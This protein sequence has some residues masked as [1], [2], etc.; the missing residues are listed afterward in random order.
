MTKI[1]RWRIS[2]SLSTRKLNIAV[3]VS[4]RLKLKDSPDVFRNSLHKTMSR[5]AT[6]DP[7]RKARVEQLRVKGD[8]SV[9]WLMAMKV[10]AVS[11]LSHLPKTFVA[12]NPSKGDLQQEY[13]F[14]K[15]VAS[16]LQGIYAGAIDIRHSAALLMHYG[17][18]SPSFDLCCKSLVEVLRDEGLY[19]SNG[20]KVAEIICHSMTDVSTLDIL[21]KLITDLFSVLQASLGWS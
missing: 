7:L 4:S 10:G 14:I 20:G 15:L 8:Q 17:R 9:L 12:R 11:A 3:P 16:F 6:P 5:A 19:Q 18:L 21:Y 13:N 1:V 2:V